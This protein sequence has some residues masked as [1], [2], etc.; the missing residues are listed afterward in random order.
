MSF[1]DKIKYGEKAEQDFNIRT[2]MEEA[3]RC[4]LCEDAPCSKGCPAGTNPGKFIRSIRLRNFKGAAETIREN[5]ILGGCCSLVCPYGNLC[6]KEC[7]RCGIDEPIKIGKLQ[8]FAIDHEK[9]SG[10]KILKAPEKKIGKKVACIGSGPASLACATELALAGID[11]TIFEQFDQP[12]GVLT[13]GIT[14]SRL[15]QDVI[16]HDIQQV[17]DLG[18]EFKMNTRIDGKDG[19]EKLLKEFD[20]VFV[21]VGLWDA[22]VPQIKGID[23]KGVYTAQEFLKNARENNGNIELGNDILVIGGGDVAMDCASTSKQLGAKNVAIVYRRTIEEAPAYY[24]EIRYIQNMGVPMIT[25]FAPEEILTDSDGKVEKMLFK[26]WDNVSE[27]SMKAD[28]VVF[29][30]GQKASDDYANINLPDGVFANGDLVNGG[31]TVVQAVADGKKSALD[32]MNYLG[33]K[34]AK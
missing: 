28:T 18:I 33:V 1:V 24:E 31:L 16:D 23:A 3:T 34:E 10:M 7:A 9:E 11:V 2:A 20:S 12:G 4:L 27:L 19:V 26:S 6:E 22:S 8:K 13:Y 14:P 5:N 30:I 15:P 29:A 21:G 17:K 32:I 25:R